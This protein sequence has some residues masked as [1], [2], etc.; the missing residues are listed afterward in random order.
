MPSNTEIIWQLEQE[1]KALRARVEELNQAFSILVAMHYRKEHDL[2]TSHEI[3]ADQL[4]KMKNTFL[5]ALYVGKEVEDDEEEGEE[6]Y[7]AQLRARMM[8]P[9][10]EVGNVA[11]VYGRDMKLL[12][13]H[14]EQE[15]EARKRGAKSR[16]SF[17]RDVDQDL[18]SILTRLEALEKK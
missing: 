10:Y 9:S 17:V 8:D 7:L 16:W 13:D 11:A 5:D 3:D 1:N 12:V 18:K 15:R 6:D 4:E 14:L 2:L